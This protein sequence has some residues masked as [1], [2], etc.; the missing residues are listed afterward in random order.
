MIVNFRLHDPVK[1]DLVNRGIIFRKFYKHLL[2]V[3]FVLPLYSD[4]QI[5]TTI[6]GTGAAGFS[7]DGSAATAAQI[8]YPHNLAIDASGNIYFPDYGNNRIRKITISTGLISTVAGTGT[9][10]F[11]GDGSAAISAQ[12]NQPTSVAFD[13]NGDLYF[14]DRGNQRVRKITTASGIINTIAGTGTAGYNSDGIVANTALLNYP[15]EVAF[16]AADNLFISDWQ[17]QRIRKVDKTTSIITTIA[18]TGTAGYNGEGISATTAQISGPCGIIFDS[19]GNI[20]FAEYSLSSRIRK[21]TI[22][23][24]LISTV[25]GIGSM[26]FNSD[27][28]AATAAQLNAPAYL[29]FDR[30]G[31]MYIGDDQNFRV[32]KIAAGTGII[33]TIAGNGT[34]GYNGDG[35]APTAAW[36]NHAYYPYFNKNDCSLYI[37]D[38]YNHRIRKVIG[39]FTDC[40]RA[41]A[42]GNKIA[43]QVL[44]AITIDNSNN[45]SWVP[46]FD[47]AGRI[48][49]EIHANGNNLG[50]VNTS[51]YTKTGF[52]RE[53]P[54]YRLYLNRNITITPQNQ[55]TSGNV[56]V[57]LYLLKSELDSLKTAVNSQSQ[58]SGVASINE[59]G[60]FKNN[61][62]CSAVGGN[63]ALPLVAVPG[64]Y[65][66]DYYLEVSISSFSSFY[67]ANKVLP[68]ILPLKIKSFTGTYAGNTHALT[69]SVA[70]ADRVIFSVERS[71]DGIHFNDIGNIVAEKTDCNKP[72]YFIDDKILTG[73]N[74]YRLRVEEV[75]GNIGY[76]TVILLNRI[77]P[78]SINLLNNPVMNNKLDINVSSS[79]VEMLEFVC[80][81]VA[82]RVLFHQIVNV[83]ENSRMSIDIANIA[84]GIY[85]IYGIG[86]HGRSN[87]IRFVKQ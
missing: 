25:A 15:N 19:V 75:N 38:T 11:S 84:N 12:I 13:S 43:C 67:F 33:S 3:L 87:T 28:I 63:D 77:N 44:P 35:I 82:G 14:T 85:W 40:Y 30:A 41:V 4:A 54:S 22:S 66:T 81:D 78:T 47:T 26:G 20:Y 80:T 45:N 72:F 9:P 58:P 62:N 73:N 27:G 21:I 10:G 53:D 59:V 16:D 61:D 49:A 23:T 31:N 42:P 68:A 1:I 83:P 65:T 29:S 50:T 79:T 56:S 57:R 6:A 69:W 74:Y 76:S 60:V 7:G 55:P 36:I 17:N 70:C 18:G 51:L 64:T 34:G 39:G 48:A 71:A 8:Y 24:G 37:V 52:C 86:K 5:I 2:I 46:I 32:R